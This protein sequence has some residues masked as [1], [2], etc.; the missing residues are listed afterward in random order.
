MDE[1][2]TESRLNDYLDGLLEGPEEEVVEEHLEACAA[3][4][5]A[6]E[7]NR[8]VVDRVR[9]LP[10]AIRPRRDL[11]DGIAAATRPV[12]PLWSEASPSPTD[13]RWRRP[14]LLAA[15][16]AVL[17]AVTATV[18]FLLVQATSGTPSPVATAPTTTSLATTAAT[19][20]EF[21]A[22]EAEHLRTTARM[23]KLLDDR[24]EALAPETRQAI[25]ASLRDID[26]AIQRLREAL[27]ADPA[28]AELIHML[29]DAYRWKIDV[30]RRAIRA[31]QT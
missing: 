28:S 9:E 31:S 22:T 11:W 29:D 12:R 21:A 24:S 19:S 26:T 13:R 16:A 6:L 7:A 4:R 2:L 3:C 18:T 15:A 8:D 5:D 14:G 25:D 10:R 17:V 27:A 23:L 1:H 30:L 20:S